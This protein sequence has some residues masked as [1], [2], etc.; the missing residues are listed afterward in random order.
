[1]FRVIYEPERGQRVP[2]RLWARSA[3][4][5]TVRQLQRLAS[6][7]YVVEFVAGMADAHV[8]EGSI[9]TRRA[10]SGFSS[11]RARA[12]SEGPLPRPTE[13]WR[14]FQGR[15]GPRATSWRGSARRVR[16]DRAPTELGA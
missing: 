13:R 10:D 1:V 4:T 14:S 12:G 8:S 6:Q 11:I 5:E 7:S 3:T 16:L 9:A 2:V 15:W